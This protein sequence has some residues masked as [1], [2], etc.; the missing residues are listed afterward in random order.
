MKLAILLGVIL[1]LSG[2]TVTAKRKMEP[3][4][5]A[6]RVGRDC[7]DSRDGLIPPCTSK[8]YTIENPVRA[9]VEV[10]LSCGTENQDVVVDLPART[11]MEVEVCPE[12]PGLVSCFI[13]TWQTKQP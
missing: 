11:K 7:C 6:E 4:I 10:T 12:S 5:V 3:R 2:I 8:V 9:P 13:L 1:G